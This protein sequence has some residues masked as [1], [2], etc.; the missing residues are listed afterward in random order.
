MV[1]LI[2]S[3]GLGNQMF[4][5]ATARSL[6]D[7]N[8]TELLINTELGFKR[9]FEFNRVFALNLFSIRFKRDKLLSF[10]FPLGNLIE[11]L[12]RKIGRHVLAPWY[13]YVND[14][15][16]AKYLID[17]Y[18]D[19]RCSIVCG[20]FV[21]EEYFRDNKE[22]IIYDFRLK[23]MVPEIINDY[24]KKIKKSEKVCIAIGIRIYQE[25]KN[26]SVR[27]N[28]FFYVQGDFYNRAMKYCQEKYGNVKFLVFTQ[29]IDW[30]LSNTELNLYDYEV[31]NTGSN[32]Q[33]AAYD[34]FL[35]SLCSHYI[36]SNSTFYFWGAWLNMNNTKEVIVPSNW[37]NSTLE[38]WTKM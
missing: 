27:N 7:R 32:D 15:A 14:E 4:Q 37:T 5:Y 9:D 28:G 26:E 29:A 24:A 10:N 33:F 36:I 22:R 13:I 25:I 2:L 6:A 8:H 30:A 21:H 3:G 17:N 19:F 38:N 18:S 31:V 11:K 20:H 1:V 12:S 16:S 23:D 35:M 34:M